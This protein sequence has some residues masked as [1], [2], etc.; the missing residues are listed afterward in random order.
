MSSAPSSPPSEEGTIANRS[1]APW[2]MLLGVLGIALALFG[3]PAPVLS[4]V[5]LVGLGADADLARRGPMFEAA[6][7]GWVVGPVRSIHAVMYVGLYTV[8][9][10]AMAGV[11]AGATARTL[12]AIDLCVSLVLLVGVARFAARRSEG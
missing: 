9:W 8:G 7:Y 12:L 5:L 6:G 11:A 1:A 3:V 2:L 10:V 4:C